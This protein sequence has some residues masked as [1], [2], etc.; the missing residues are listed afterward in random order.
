MIHSHYPELSLVRFIEPLSFILNACFWSIL[1]YKKSTR[2]HPKIGYYL[3]TWVP[4][5]GRISSI[6]IVLYL[7]LLFD[8]ILLNSYLFYPATS[9][10]AL[11]V[12]LLI[13]LRSSYEFHWK[14]CFSCVNFPTVFFL[15][16]FVPRCLFEQTLY[17]LRFLL[18]LHLQLRSQLYGLSEKHRVIFMFEFFQTDKVF[19]E[20]KVNLML[21]WCKKSK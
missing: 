17:F 9:S 8:H 18:A 10:C 16:S 5:L 19:N 12:F 1:P 21:T 11:E 14:S 13:W 3:C 2:H 4:I 15:P 7:S 6:L 20:M